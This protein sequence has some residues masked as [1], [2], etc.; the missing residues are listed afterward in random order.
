MRPSLD[1]RHFAFKR[2]SQ[3]LWPISWSH[4]EAVS[5]PLWALWWSDSKPSRPSYRRFST[6]SKVQTRPHRQI[7]VP[8]QMQTKYSDLMLIL[9]C[10]LSLLF[11]PHLSVSAS[12][13]W[14]GL[15]RVRLE[16]KPPLQPH[17]L[18]GALPDL[19]GGVCACFICVGFVCQYETLFGHILFAGYVIMLTSWPSIYIFPDVA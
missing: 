11:S 13:G 2:S 3:S 17:S 18:P 5:F 7:Q 12:R 8:I 19:H 16:K 14:G 15:G 1:S 4:M 9:T 10:L 6:R